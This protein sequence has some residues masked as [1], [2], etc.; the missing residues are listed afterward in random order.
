MSIL[1]DAFEDLFRDKNIDDY[2]LK[3]K[4]NNYKYMNINSKIW[5]YYNNDWISAEIIDK[6][7]KI[8]FQ[9]YDNENGYEN[10]IIDG[11]D[12]IIKFRNN[13]VKY[14]NNLVDLHHLNEPSILNTLLYRYKQD[15]IYTLNGN[16]LISINPYKNYQYME[17]KWLKN[18]TNKRKKII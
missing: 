13:Y 16:I 2:N 3:I 11:N 7:G 1:A 4:I 14:I 9:Q 6:S 8:F 5:L 12:N 10:I 15:K 17:M 18:I